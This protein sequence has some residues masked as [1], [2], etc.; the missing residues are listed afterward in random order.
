GVEAVDFLHARLANDPD[1]F[2]F[3]A[4][5]EKLVN[6]DDR[7]VDI[8]LSRVHDDVRATISLLT[9]IGTA[10]ALE[11][12]K[13]I[14]AQHPAE[15]ARIDH[16]LRVAEIIAQDRAEAAQAFAAAKQSFERGDVDNAEHLA[17]FA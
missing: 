4:H 3:V 10:R 9:S 13:P 1:V 11:E 5:A 6:G 15:Q 12:L 16:D 17:R 8:A 2:A 14:L 7:F